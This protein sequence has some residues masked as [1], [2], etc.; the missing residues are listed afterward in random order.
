MAAG[1]ENQMDKRICD[2]CGKNEAN[3]SYKVK[4]SIFGRHYTGGSG[5]R[6]IVCDWGLYEKIDI[7]GECAER[8]LGVSNI[9]KSPGHKQ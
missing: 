2:V 4:K 3:T 6:G 9:I 8:L 5:A 7:C 1:R